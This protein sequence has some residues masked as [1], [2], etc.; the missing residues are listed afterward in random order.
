MTTSVRQT[1]NWRTRR[2]PDETSQT[3]AGD[4]L[5]R[6]KYSNVAKIASVCVLGFGLYYAYQKIYK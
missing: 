1:P 4:I 6:A 2:G 3:P 5:P